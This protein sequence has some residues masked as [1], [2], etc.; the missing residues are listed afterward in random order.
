M[1]KYLGVLGSIFVILFVAVFSPLFEI[2]DV[3]IKDD[4][5]CLKNS[6]YKIEEQFIG[7]NLIFLNTQKLSQNAKDMI[8][9]LK[10]VKIKKNFPTQIILSINAKSPIASIA[11]SDFQITEDGLVIKKDDRLNLPTIFLSEGVKSTF[12][13]NTK[14]EDKS[15]I[16]ATKI[17]AGLLK[18]DFIPTTIRII[19]SDEIVVYSPQNGFV[20]FSS[21]KD[22]DFQVNSLQLILARSKID[23]SKIAKID[24]RFDKPVISYQ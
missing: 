21:E 12:N 15:I 6:N 4:Q 11:E 24:L 20:V 8:V 1:A 17:A 5:D 7:K 3:R 19:A 16:A 14:I 18:S 23:A 13:P 22:I 10:E 2:K 9:C